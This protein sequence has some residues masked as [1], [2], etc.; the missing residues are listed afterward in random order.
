M[1]SSGL[2]SRKDGVSSKRASYGQVRFGEGSQGPFGVRVE[3]WSLNCIPVELMSS[4][5]TSESRC[6][7]VC[8]SPQGP[9]CTLGPR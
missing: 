9:A 2:S 8:G 3:L 1:S 7:C 4:G 6:R 5:C